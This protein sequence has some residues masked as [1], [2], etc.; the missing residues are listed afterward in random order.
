MTEPIRV[1]V[2]APGATEAAAQVRTFAGTVAQSGSASEKA[3]AAHTQAA[4]ATQAAGNA[5][6][7]AA[8]K[9]KA[10]IRTLDEEIIR[11]KRL[12][13]QSLVTAAARARL[14]ESSNAADIGAIRRFSRGIPGGFGRELGRGVAE[15]IEG[16]EGT[17]LRSGLGTAGAGLAIGAISFEAIQKVF[18][19]QL[20]LA[21]R[22]TEIRFAIIKTLEEAASRAS[23][24]GKSAQ[25][26]YGEAL[27][28]LA[29]TGGDVA[30]EHAKDYAKASNDASGIAAYADASSRFKDSGTQAFALNAAQA[31]A[32]SGGG[33][34]KSAM[35]KLTLERVE[36]A[37]SLGLDSSSLA[38]E[39][40]GDDHGVGRL[41]AADVNAR[42]ARRGGSAVGRALDANTGANIDTAIAGI[43]KIP[44]ALGSALTD[45][46]HAR[47]PMTGVLVDQNI[48]SRER[49]AQLQAAADV[50][51]RQESAGGFAPHILTALNYYRDAFAG[52]GIGKGSPA[53]Q[54][55]ERSNEKYEMAA[56][57]LDDAAHAL[58]GVGRSSDRTEGSTP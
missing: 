18:E 35:D 38:G 47:D 58:R 41:S 7:S 19:G 50:Q 20:E 53:Y 43:G 37:Q 40:Y 42:I 48:A 30:V 1:P 44:A 21:K 39:L 23:D 29:S 15:G 8:V 52:V 5:A 22:E 46:A 6:E 14:G 9:N 12:E 26:K 51:K 25:D 10:H 32:R 17:G 24:L 13:E 4:K 28:S 36:R 34:V 16:T 45:K 31:Y 33:S 11:L 3:A 27:T 2:T 57:A 56:A 49:D 54:L 55:E